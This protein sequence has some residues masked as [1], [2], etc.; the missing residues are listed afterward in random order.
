[1]KSRAGKTIGLAGWSILG[2]LIFLLNFYILWAVGFLDCAAGKIVS[3]LASSD[4]VEINIVNLRSDIFWATTVDSVVVITSSGVRVEVLAPVIEGSALDYL[5]NRHLSGLAVESVEVEIPP[6]SGRKEPSGL[7]DVLNDIS[8]GF[9]TGIDHLDIAN[10]RV[11]DINGSIVDSIFLR[12]GIS[13]Q[14]G[15]ELTVDSVEAF[16]RNVG[17]L[18]GSGYLQL[19]DSTLFSSG[20]SGEG[21]Y[22]K[23]DISGSLN[24]PSENMDISARGELEL[25]LLP[26]PA[27]G[28]AVFSSHITGSLTE[29]ELSGNIETVDLCLME[30]MLDVVADTI[31]LTFSGISFNDVLFAGDGFNG[32][33][34][35]R[36]EFSDGWTTSTSITLTDLDISSLFADLPKTDLSGSIRI[37][38]EG[39]LSGPLYT[40][41]E[42]SLNESTVDLFSV[43]SADLTASFNRSSWF[44]DINL[45]L[46]DGWVACSGTG[47]MTSGWKPVNYRGELS[48][49]IHSC[50]LEDITAGFLLPEVQRLGLDLD[51][52]GTTSA[53][54]IEGEI[55]AS[56]IKYEELEAHGM[57]W[58]G[59]LDI[60]N[61]NLEG[62]GIF[63]I[64]TVFTPFSDFSFNAD[65]DYSEGILSLGEMEIETVRGIQF[66]AEGSIVLDKD[67]T[68]QIA[69]LNLNRTKLRLISDGFLEL[70][71][72]GGGI[73][74]DTL[75]MQ[76]PHGLLSF[77]GQIGSGDS[78]LIR[79]HINDVDLTSLAN[80]F[81][82]PHGLSGIGEFNI[83]LIRSADMV[84]ADLSGSIRA[85]SLGLYY[86]DSI[87]I[88]AGLRNDIIEV[89]GVYSWRNG[90]RSGISCC[91][92]SIWNSSGELEI[93]MS[94]LVSF[95]LEL[96]ETV[97][98]I[99]S[100]LPAGIR[101]NGG[102]ISAHADYIRLP[103]K[104][105][106]FT[107][108]IIARTEE[109]Y[110]TS[111]GTMIPGV[112]LHFTHNDPADSIFTTIINLSAAD[113]E[114]GTLFIQ[115]RA[116]F[117]RYFPEPLI[118]KFIAVANMDS[119]QLYISDFANLLVDGKLRCSS[120]DIATKPEIDGV[121]NI[122]E[123]IVT[124]PP[125]GEGETGESGNG[126][127]FDINV[128]V[129]GSRGT[130]FRSSFADIELGTDIQIVT[131]EEQ[132]AILGTVEALRGKV[133][134]LQKEFIILEGHVQFH[135]TVPMS[136]EMSVLAETRIR[137]A[138]D[139]E[140]YTVQV[141]IEG[142]IESPVISLFGEGPDGLVLAHEDIL[143]LLALGI[144]YG[145]FQQ[146]GSGAL[147]SE[148]TTMAQGYLG[149]LLARS[150]REGIGLD[151]LELTPELIGNENNSLNVNIGKYLLPDLFVS[152]EDDIFSSDPGTLRAQYYLTRDFSVIASTK[153]TFQGEQEPSFELHYTF[154]Y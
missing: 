89:S 21:P 138:V 18:H 154:R 10:G 4:E 80:L 43:N 148:L 111:I 137:G 118:G 101:T 39:D 106:D 117:L 1:M 9:V 6:S 81:G 141:L 140:T 112:Q 72:H 147:E 85:P 152:F 59:Q 93:D 19:V 44:A 105:Y 87:T 2:F 79:T 150:L 125:S 36:Y 11:M 52:A 86:A 95:E 5:L 136:A 139:N 53:A 33:C 146:L 82:I 97:D 91:L 73:W 74:I 25:A 57:Y 28:Y 63:R 127:P 90:T 22:G 26:F 110:L 37:D 61:G 113:P 60:R 48:A 126:L 50:H 98:W 96:E 16:V 149:Q 30:H 128:S 67:I 107:A 121:I 14:N 23:L 135:G 32:R 69:E 41:I 66:T 17:M 134:L 38:S 131:S 12:T 120:T 115:A 56:S 92:D 102:E 130:W 144:T 58:E 46:A 13:L 75:W 132:L 129:R 84:Q 70:L 54:S 88:D 108:E 109:L 145:Q 143:T 124:I 20:F 8:S 62:L 51:I 99:L 45:D 34:E 104:K 47:E 116:E 77:S 7:V 35:G 3:T 15:I 78:L 123:G 133:Y 142:S 55:T 103:E 94:N 24:G 49:D 114:L 42:C 76:T 100:L 83:N 122:L 153:S 65:L 151:E 68:M 29:P 27:S 40:A 31:V 64:D 119:I 71:L